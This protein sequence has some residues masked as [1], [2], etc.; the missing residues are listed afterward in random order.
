[1]SGPLDHWTPERYREHMQSEGVNWGPPPVAD[2]WKED[3]ETD[4]GDQWMTFDQESRA[5]RPLAADELFDFTEAVRRTT[6]DS[7]EQI[8]QDI[9]DHAQ[10]VFPDFPRDHPQTEAET[11]WVQ[12]AMKD[13]GVPA[14]TRAQAQWA[15]A[16][17]RNEVRAESM[18]RH[19][20]GKQMH[21]GPENWA[22]IKPQPV[23]PVRSLRQ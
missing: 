15:A 3:L 22:Q 8:V 7:T 17:E 19:P 1:M 13:Y 18:T 21:P 10:D 4:V 5:M 2:T 14:E 12:D 16:M 6:P 23:A 11:R 20:A 9:R